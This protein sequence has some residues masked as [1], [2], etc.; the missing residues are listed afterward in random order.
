[1][2]EEERKKK[3]SIPPGKIHLIIDTDAKN[4]IDDQFAVSWAL[5]SKDHFYVDA[6]YAAPFSHKTFF[7]NVGRDSHGINE[8]SSTGM[9]Q[10]Y[11]EIIKLCDILGED[12]TG[13]VFRGADGYINDR[14]EPVNSDASED[15]IQRARAST[16]TI[17]IASIGACTNV[18]SAL[19]KAP[20]IAD[21]IVVVWLGGQQPIFGHGNEFNMGQDPRAAHHLFGCGVPVVWIPCMNIASLLVLTD[22]DVRQ[23][24]LGKSKIGTYLTEIM[25][26]QF[27]N[28]DKALTRATTHRTLQLKGREDQ[29]EEYFAQFPSRHVAW[30][31]TVWDVATIAYLKNPGWVQSMLINAP[32]IQ[33]DCTYF[34]DNN[35]T[36]SIRMATYC[37][38]D[39]IF[40]DMIA[41]LNHD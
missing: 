5:R 26:E 27:P 25:L 38:R 36:N 7:D 19:L 34:E 41:C 23:K 8:N 13:R 35:R 20:D 32:V 12:T 4:E 33:G 29:T 17:Y 16:D 28:L 9:E 6:I 40:G 15:L 31:R 24:L 30:S 1:M 11:D 22:D 2:N 18:A 3:L 10:S 21:K 37:Q 39:L 14:C